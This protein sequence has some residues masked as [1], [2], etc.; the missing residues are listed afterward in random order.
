MIECEARVKKWGNSLGIVIPREQAQKGN[1]RENQVVKVLIV[2]KKTVR[3]KDLYGKFTE[4]KKST[5][6]IVAENKKELGSKWL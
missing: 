4:W 1:V 2:P 5:E 6:R 3:V